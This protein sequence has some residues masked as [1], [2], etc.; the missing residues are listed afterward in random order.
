[1]RILFPATA[2]LIAIVQSVRSDVLEL[3]NGTTLNGKYAAH[4]R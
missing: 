3:K 4:C 2:A 1:M